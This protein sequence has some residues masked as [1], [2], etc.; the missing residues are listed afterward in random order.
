MGDAMSPVI[1]PKLSVSM[2][3][4]SA[5]SEAADINIQTRH[6]HPSST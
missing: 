2:P 6:L 3:D 1:K 4:L 5:I